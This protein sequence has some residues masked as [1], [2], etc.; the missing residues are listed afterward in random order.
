MVFFFF[1]R[2]TVIILTIFIFNA[3]FLEIADLLCQGKQ[4]VFGEQVSVDQL[5]A[6]AATSFEEAIVLITTRSRVNARK[7][8]VL[9]SLELIKCFVNEL[10][11]FGTD[12]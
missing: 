12:P 7:I 10:S 6:L 11:M 1:L 3:L 4:F 2:I 8:H 5:V 9:V